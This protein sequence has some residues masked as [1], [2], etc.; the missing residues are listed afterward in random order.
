MEIWDQ[1]LEIRIAAAQE[2]VFEERCQKLHPGQ[3][4]S[5]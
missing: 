2:R 5:A 1:P 3:A 4:C